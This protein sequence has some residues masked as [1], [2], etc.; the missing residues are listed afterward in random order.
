MGVGVFI[1]KACLKIVL[2]C[3]SICHP[4]MTM[5]SKRLQIQ[6]HN[7]HNCT[8][9]VTYPRLGTPRTIIRLGQG[10]LNIKV[11]FSDQRNFFVV[12]VTAIIF[13]RRNTMYIM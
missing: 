13:H 9:L 3:A 12:R 5:T 7:W 8:V 4:G 10:I 2:G 6:S 11:T 1:F